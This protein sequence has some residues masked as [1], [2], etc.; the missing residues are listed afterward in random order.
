M[1][2]IFLPYAGKN[3]N[4]NSLTM[5]GDS[6]LAQCYV[7]PNGTVRNA[8]NFIPI[9]LAMSGQ[10]FSIAK[11]FA[12]S[13]YRSDQYLSATNVSG[14]FKTNAY[15]LMVYGIVN[16]ISQ[17]NNTVDP[18]NQYIKPI[19]LQWIAS[20]RSVILCTETGA[21]SFAASGANY[22]G[23]V[24]K[25]NTQI[26]EFC[27][28]NP[29]AVLFDI[30]SIVMM[31]NVSCTINSAYTGDGVHINLVAGASMVGRAF[32]ALLSKLATP[33]SGLVKSVDSIYSNGGVQWFPN[34]LF[35]TTTGGNAGAG[36][37]LT[38]A[39]PYGITS[40]N[41]PAGTTIVGSIVAGAYGNKYQMVVNTTQAGLVKLQMDLTGV[42][43]EN[44]GDVFYA[45]CQWDLAAGATNFQWAGGHLESNRG[46]TTSYVE[47]G[48][49]ASYNGSL[50]S[51]ALSWVSETERLTVQAGT[52]NWL[53]HYATMYFAGAGNAT[54]NL[55]RLGVW[56][57]PTY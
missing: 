41:A 32:G 56:R 40:V 12:Q 27:R 9:G 24:V 49:A 33:I 26:R 21:N 8:A 10:R 3:Y 48:Y 47:D 23:P 37:F 1:S 15:W 11:N 25:Y 16:D 6:R 20:G 42:A 53:T 19:V 35:T 54:L 7:D 36:G 57:L 51:G 17:L 55:S 18:W 13:G 44:V 31:P 34:P 5:L 29:N 38:G 39:V 28:T 43:V 30:A 52:R 2:G 45:N 50:A 14:A 4:R 46:S 22:L